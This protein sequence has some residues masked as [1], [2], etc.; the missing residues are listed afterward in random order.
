[1]A[2]K[3]TL[4]PSYGWRIIFIAVLCTVF[5]VWGAYDLFVKIPRQE[6]AAAEYQ[7]LNEEKQ[8]LEQVLSQGRAP[9]PEQ[10]ERYTQIEQQ[11][12][13]IGE[14]PAKPS[15]FNRL[16]QWFYISCILATPYC[17]SLY[18]R[19]R[20]QVYELD[21]QG[22]LHFTGDPQLGS[23]AWKKDEIADIDMSRWMRKSIAYAV[24][25]D[26]SRLML[27][28]YLH[29]HLDRIVGAIASQHYPDK[30]DKNASPI[31]PGSAA[32]SNSSLAQAQQAENGAEDGMEA[33]DKLP[34]D[35][36]V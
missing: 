1:M 22:T 7:A 19:A 17:I 21:D 34:T 31:K 9:T 3:T 23:G 13:A 28:A 33:E 8:S 18:R 26:G 2:I 12:R 6:A 25:T 35:S 20:R 15:K 30:W 24:H 4:A 10:R 32:D 29:K 27:D 36:A 14:A 11:L 16:T 5:S